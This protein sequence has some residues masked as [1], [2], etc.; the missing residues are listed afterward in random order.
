[1]PEKNIKVPP[2]DLDAEIS[3][4]GAL[5][6]DPMS[7]VR[8]TDILASHDFYHPAHK[9]IFEVIISLFEKGE[10]IDILTVSSFLKKE[11]KA[12]AAG[13]ADY[14]ADLVA[15]VPTAAHIEQYAKI[16]KELSVR[17]E[18]IHASSEINEEA[19]GP[20][21]FDM[22]LDSVEQKIF[23][24]SQ[25]SRP[26]RFFPIRDELMSAYDRI[27]KLH[28][29]D[30][31]LRGVSSHFHQLDNILS[32][33]QKSD[34]IILGARPS[35]GKTAFALDISRNIALNGKSVGVFS[36]E[37]SREQIID[38]L[39]ASQAKIPL[40]RLRT[41][42][43]QGEMEFA[44]IQQALDELSKTNLF[45]D[46]TPSPTI[47]QMR[48]AARRLQLEHGLDFM[49]IDYLQLINPRNSNEGMVQQVTEISRGLKALARELNIPV[50]ALSQLSREVDK[51]DIKIPRLSDLRESGCLSGDT[52]IQ[53]VSGERIPIKQLAERQTQTPVQVFA[54]HEDYKIHKAT[55]TKVFYSG[56]KT[57]YKLKTR[58]GFE[59]KA[60]SNHPFL[61]IGGW[62]RVE[63]F[64]N[65]DAIGIPRIL[66][67]DSKNDSMSN[68]EIILLAHLL[69]DGCILPKQPYHY[70]SG[71]MENIN[72]VKN[73]VSALFGINGRIVKQKNWFHVY[74]TSPMKLTKNR[75]HPI[76]EW[77][78]RLGIDR[79]RSYDKKIPDLIFEQNDNK[80]K[81]FLKHLWATDGNISVKKLKG[82]MDSGNIY[83]ATSSE[84]LG[85]Q[86]QHLLLRLGIHSVR[87]TVLSKKGYR[88]MY[89]IIVSGKENQYVFLK[90]IGAVGK[91]GEMS[92][93]ILPM[94]EKIV[95]NT[96][97]DVLPK[98]IWKTLIEPAK[99][100]SGMSWRDLS[101]TMNTSYCGSSLFQ[102]GLSRER[103]ERV[104]TA[105]CPTLQR[106]TTGIEISNILKNL[107]NSDIFWDTIASIEKIGE[108]DVYDATVP[109]FNNF[110]ANDFVV[111][112][113]LEQDADIV[114]FIHRKDRERMDVPEE[115]QNMVD[116]IVAKHRNGPLGTV[117]LRFDP[118][119]VSFHTIDTVHQAE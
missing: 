96:N 48:A 64:T 9:I 20:E 8:V 86:V 109:E 92:N 32:G 18:L 101:A 47:L 31:A 68:D 110:L 10:P 83:Y 11:N 105:L 93:K 42:R 50:L 98:D 22:F 13:G 114:M 49:V 84:T 24:I 74:L 28:R 39:I 65:G 112:N 116:I 52:L 29:G 63:N 27:E 4:L 40:W 55:M 77:F 33:F 118:E 113:S 57:V 75:K 62:A 54:V 119:K 59:I 87:K 25:K 72:Y 99:E 94:L 79:V 108:E 100:I 36:I 66:K 15:N 6:I 71:E 14:L 38:R 45:I 35:F 78:E 117:K 58:S 51:R 16:V 97:V 82:R 43:L 41:G 89:H 37:M 34:L 21:E 106:T 107:S 23:N 95:S 12:K 53:L 5:M 46:D 60:S 1:M 56:K 7:V 91:K 26:Q 67:I 61:K 76:S 90:T 19:F 69:G 81:L 104:Q 111:H 80:L 30:G 85:C 115:E 103:L 88:P 17:R 44:L 3:V 70:T 102:K 2:N 73:S